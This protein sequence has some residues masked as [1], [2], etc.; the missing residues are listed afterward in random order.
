MRNLPKIPFDVRESF[1]DVY[2]VN[3][4]HNASSDRCSLVVVEKQSSS[5][6]LLRRMRTA[7]DQFVHTGSPISPHGR[8]RLTSWHC[9]M[10]CA[11]R[12]LLHTSN[13]QR[14]P[15]SGEFSSSFP[16]FSCFGRRLNSPLFTLCTN[17]VLCSL[18]STKK[19]AFSSKVRPPVSG[20]K[21]WDM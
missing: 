2:D 20:E 7:Q 5:G 18:A 17:Q 21:A 16:P 9:R 4:A 11:S 12:S 8:T 10:A 6:D 1:G 13:T 19:F 14:L 3:D 15:R